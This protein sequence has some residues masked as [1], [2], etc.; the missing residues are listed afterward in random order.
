MP[1]SEGGS[2]GHE[3]LRILCGKHNRRREAGWE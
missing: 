3:N 2:H 1:F